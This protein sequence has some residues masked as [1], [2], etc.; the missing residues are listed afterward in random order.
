VKLFFSRRYKMWKR[1]AIVVVGV[2]ILLVLSVGCTPAVAPAESQTAAIQIDPVSQLA[3]KTTTLYGA[4]FVPGENIRVEVVMLKDGIPVAINMGMGA[5]REQWVANAAGAIVG[6]IRVPHAT[7]A[8]PG[9]YTVTAMGD[10]GSI[11]VCPLGV[12]AP[13]E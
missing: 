6:V 9:V 8:D 7:I 10:Q 2:V 5:A 12:L 13:P 3:R 4:G 11:A 1:V